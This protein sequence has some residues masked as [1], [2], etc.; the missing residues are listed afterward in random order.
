MS[1]EGVQEEPLRV[2][3]GG[4][5]LL[6][7]GDG[8]AHRCPPSVCSVP[9]GGLQ[10]R[11]WRQQQRAGTRDGR[12]LEQI[13]VTIPARIADDVPAI[14]A[15]LGGRQRLFATGCPARG[16]SAGSARRPHR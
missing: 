10:A 12:M 7:L 13:E 11:P 8:L 5:V 16:T 9:A 2:G 3:A 6:P 1:H 15:G 14:Y 4:F